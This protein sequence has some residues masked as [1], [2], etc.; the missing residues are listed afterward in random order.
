M[1]VHG[2][3][4]LDYERAVETGM[5]LIE[6]GENPN[7]G[8]LI[9]CG[10]NMG[11]RI[12]DLIR[13]EYDQLKSKEFVVQEKKTKKR[14]KVVANS[15]VFEA[16]G[17][18]PDTASKDLGG[19]IFVSN[20]GT[21][22]SPQHVNRLLKKYFDDSSL[23]ISTHSLRKTWGR[24]YYEKFHDKGGLS[25]LQLQFNHATPADTLRYIGITQDKLDGM[26]ER[27]V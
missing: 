12:S 14:R 1:T 23:K 5:N 26:Y 17:K 22:Y 27:V 7:I 21:V 6:T 3:D 20:K 9:V 24:R 19:K 2:S 8:L 4:A 11:L 10:V 13:L 18:M 16:L 15:V 25:D